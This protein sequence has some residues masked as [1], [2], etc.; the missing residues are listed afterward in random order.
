MD[1][2]KIALIRGKALICLLSFFSLF[3]LHKNENIFSVELPSFEKNCIEFLSLRKEK[4]VLFKRP[5]LR[6]LIAWYHTWHLHGASGTGYTVSE[7]QHSAALRSAS[8]LISLLECNWSSCKWSARTRD[9]TLAVTTTSPEHAGIP[10]PSE[11][12]T[13]NHETHCF[14]IWMN[15]LYFQYLF[16]FARAKNL[17]LPKIIQQQVLSP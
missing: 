8:K 9:D 17:I 15:F 4:A 14:V 12:T 2:R 16:I 10:M 3:C 6:P 5:T 13:T 1:W 11:F 7:C